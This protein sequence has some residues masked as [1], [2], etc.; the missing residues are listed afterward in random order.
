MSLIDY[1]PRTDAPD[2]DEVYTAFATWAEDEGIAL[3]DH[4]EEALLAICS[5]ANVIA[6]TPTG[7]GK[8]LIA[9]AAHFNALAHQRTSFYTAPIKALVSE[10]FFELCAQFGTD[11]V[12]MLTGDAAVNPDAP[13]ICCTA[14]ILANL[15][16]REGPDL[17]CDSVVADEFHFYADPDRGWAWQVPL[18]ELPRAAFTL[19]SATLGDTTFFENDLTRRTGRETTLITG[20][21]RPVPLEYEYRKTPLHDT[22]ENLADH[23]RTPAYIV[24]FTQA[25]ALETAQA[26]SSLKL[27]DKDTKTAINAALGGFRFTTKFGATLARLVRSGIGVHHAGMLPKYRRLVERLAQT[28]LL[29]IICGTDTL[30]VGI[31]V[32]IRTVVFTGLAKYDGRR[33]RRLR[34]R[35]FHQIAGRAGRAGYDTIG[36]VVCQAPEHVIENE[37]ALAKFGTD[38]KKRKK[39]AK[40]KPPEGFIGWSED[41]FNGLAEANPEPLTSRMHMNHAMLINLLARPG[42]AFDHTRHLIEDSHADRPTQLRM[43]RT[44]LTIAR[45][46][47]DAD[48]IAIED[49]TIKLT[50]DLPDH[51]AL[52]QPLAPFAIAALDLLDPQSD[53]YPMDIVSIVEATLEGPGQIL[54]AQRNKAKTDAID[55]MKADGLDY[56]DRMNRLEDDDID[57]PKPLADLLTEAFDAYR[58]SHPWAADYQLQPKSILREIWEQHMTFGEYIGAYRLPR[59]EGLLLRYLTSAYK[60]LT[61]TLPA[62]TG[63]TGGTELDDLTTW[64]G[65]TIRQTDSSLINEWEQLTNPADQDDDIDIGRPSTAFT[66]N[67][68]AF[69]IAVRN[70]AFR[71]IELAAADRPDALAAQDTGW[72]TAK[73]DT[74]LERYYD[75]HDDIGTTTAARSDQF[76]DIDKHDRTWTVRQVIDDPAGN[77]DWAMTF[78]VDLDASD[79]AG[80]VK[81]TIEDFTD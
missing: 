46:L 2:D 16:L 58:L 56:Y 34:A 23:D 42:S 60:A 75:T 26:L 76:L 21:T 71:H 49:G 33:T 50:V 29:K 14:E 9:A 64:L 3:Y 70:A 62:G 27:V 39:M 37:K 8:T 55:A 47:R 11:N 15:A 18:L 79:A 41:T 40:K 81:M 74:A 43:A 61:Q 51:F 52:N 12:G 13:L 53:T 20:D 32:P 5:G 63:G 31:N 38:P 17:D 7:S 4:Q 65:E 78:T 25:A 1:L 30:G 22:A 44:A 57:Y 45:T 72:P 80:T 77:R 19:M 35:E 28:G 69:T 68:R 36:Y 73:W 10:K 67:E 54:A 6:G 48:I 24:H 66:A 59:A